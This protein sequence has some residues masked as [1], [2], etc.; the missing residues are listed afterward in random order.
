MHR[1]GWENTKTGLI[2]MVT[3]LEEQ[4]IVSVLLPYGPTGTDFSLHFAD[5]LQATEKIK[6]M[7][8]LPAYGV[9]PEY[10]LKTFD[11]VQRWG[12]NRLD[13]NLIAGN[14][15]G[16]IES[17][18]LE[19]YPWGIDLVDS[20]EKRVNITE[21]WME[22]FTK[23]L[24]DHERVINGPMFE[25]VLYVVG[26]S[27]TTI[28]TAN[29]YADY[30]IINDRMLTKETMSKL[31]NVKPILVIDPLILDDG[32]GI[33][34]IEYNEYTYTKRGEHMVRWLQN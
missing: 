4:N 7:I 19:N 27:D 23:L 34:D 15:R 31:T 24:K 8:A 22:K 14:Y 20:H 26:A 3:F 32:Q 16:E 1:N 17:T 18:M 21:K 29:K 30:L 12:R 33:N 2:D 13:L 6:I 5:M 10:A 25:T 9:A 11:T 28:R